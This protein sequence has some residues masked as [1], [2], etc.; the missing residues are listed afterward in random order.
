MRRARVAAAS[1]AVLA[2]GAL[3]AGAPGADGVTAPSATTAPSPP[4]IPQITLTPTSISRA[5]QPTT[6]LVTGSQFPASQPVTISLD[7]TAVGSTMTDSGGGFTEPVTTRGL[8]CAAHQVKA[9]EQAK[10]GAS[11]LLFSASAPLRVTGCPMTLAISPAVLEPGELTQVT[12]TGFTPGTPVILS[13]R[14]SVGGA[15]L[16]GTLSVAVGTGGAISGFFLVMPN[17]LL[18]PRQLV[19]TQ[20]ATKLTANALVDPGPTQPSARDRLIYRG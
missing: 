7:G 19:A 4:G 2:G 16:L 9:S 11:T 20:G 13:W 17:D 18:G 1:A 3:L 5:H 15:P 14:A 12:G 8:G 10:P 6:V